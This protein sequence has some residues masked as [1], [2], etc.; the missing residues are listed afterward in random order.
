[1]S[2]LTMNLQGLNDKPGIKH[3]LLD[4]DMMV[5]TIGFAVEE[6]L[7]WPDGTV[8]YMSDSHA[9]R[10]MVDSRVAY[11]RDGLEKPLQLVLSGSGKNWRNTLVADSYKAGRSRKPTAYQLIRDYL[12]NEYAA[13]VSKN[14]E[15]A[16]DLLAR[17]ATNEEGFC[18]V[19]FDKDFFTVAGYFAHLGSKR[20]YKPTV[21]QALSFLFFQGLNGDRVDNYFGVKYIGPAKAK[22][23]LEYCEVHNLTVQQS[24]LALK[25]AI[26]LWAS[27]KCLDWKV[28]WREFTTSLDQAS[29]TWDGE[30]AGKGI[31]IRRVRK[32]K[33]FE[34]EYFL[35]YYDPSH[36]RNKSIKKL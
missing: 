3:V 28:S 4:A 5:Y 30:E 6:R 20:L 36:T 23:L 19:S 10:R 25:K 11:F 14:G 2:R 8:E 18:I 31:S 35:P 7:D 9:A 17:L 15:E 29:V 22:R 12:T 13:L 16:D 34:F 24:Y 1:M 26:K 21:G 33:D 27:K 32:Y